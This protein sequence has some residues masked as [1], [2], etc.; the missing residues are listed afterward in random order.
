MRLPFFP[1]RLPCTKVLNEE[2]VGQPSISRKTRDFGTCI[3][4]R[5]PTCSVLSSRTSR[6]SSLCGSII[7]LPFSLPGMAL[8]CGKLGYV[9]ICFSFEVLV[10]V[11]TCRVPRYLGR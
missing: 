5:E 8:R 10:V 4:M 6:E 7:L 1:C 3:T 9:C 2:V 11:Y